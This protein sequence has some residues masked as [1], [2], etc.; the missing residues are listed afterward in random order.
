VSYGPDDEY[1]YDDL[2]PPPRDDDVPVRRVEG[3]TGVVVDPAQLSE[4][5][6][7]NL[8]REFLLREI[9]N[10]APEASTE[11]ARI[12]RIVAALRRREYL[13]TFDPETSSV[14][15]AAPT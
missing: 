1:Q 12:A 2:T 11:D 8:A 5:A 10:D 9:G 3:A 14:G 13:I 7:W 15:V 6:L 4:A